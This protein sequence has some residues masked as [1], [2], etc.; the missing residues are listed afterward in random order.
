MKKLTKTQ[1]R[2]REI[3]TV[4]LPILYVFFW[5]NF[6]FIFFACLFLSLTVLITICN[7]VINCLAYEQIVDFYPMLHKAFLD[8]RHF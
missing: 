3:E 7:W 4:I 8:L 2:L 6:A 1:R 5:I